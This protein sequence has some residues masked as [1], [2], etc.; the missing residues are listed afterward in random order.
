[1]YVWDHAHLYDLKRGEVTVW[2]GVI[3]RN[4]SIDRLRQR[5]YDLPFDA[6]YH[7]PAVFAPELKS[8]ECLVANWQEGRILHRQVC[9]LPPLRQQ[10]LVLSFFHE[11]SHKSIA[12]LL[13]LPRGTVKSHIRRALMALRPALSLWRT[14]YEAEFEA[15]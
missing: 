11:L 15:H 14:G 2:L 1:M 8:P 12:D 6:Q 9:E 5:R 13:K 3:A 7:Q 4:R 10:L